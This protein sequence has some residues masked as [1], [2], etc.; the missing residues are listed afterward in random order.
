MKLGSGNLKLENRNLELEAGNMKLCPGSGA[1]KSRTGN[2][3][4]ER[5]WYLPQIELSQ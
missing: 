1:Q 4:I 2:S 5:L 3:T